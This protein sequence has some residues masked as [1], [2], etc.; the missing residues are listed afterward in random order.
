MIRISQQALTDACNGL[1]SAGL[2]SPPNVPR[3]EEVI[4]IT[5]NRLRAVPPGLDLSG[6]QTNLR[7][8]VSPLL[9]YLVTEHDVSHLSP[10]SVSDAVWNLYAAAASRMQG[11]D[12]L[13]VVTETPDAWYE[14]T[15]PLIE[16]KVEQSNHDQLLRAEARFP[17]WP[18]ALALLGV[19][20]LMVESWIASGRNRFYI[21]VACTIMVAAGMAAGWFRFSA[22]WSSSTSKKTAKLIDRVPMGTAELPPLEPLNNAAAPPAAQPP[23]APPFPGGQPGPSSM[24]RAWHS[25]WIACD[26]E[27]HGQHCSPGRAAWSRVMF[28]SRYA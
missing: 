25:R 14:A 9:D 5:R 23:E 27:W 15:L 4:Q 10:Q 19:I 24:R 28:A 22:W 21:V 1:L 12:N 20:G 8:V 3:L 6:Q 26:A 16:R 11:V 7:H 2:A 18:W 17:Y 13:A